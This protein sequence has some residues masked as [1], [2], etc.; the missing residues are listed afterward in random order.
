MG[1]I[2][3]GVPNSS[4]IVLT[5][6]DYDYSFTTEQERYDIRTK[7]G[8]L[9]SYLMPESTY[10]RFILPMSFVSSSNQ[11]LVGSWHSTA[12]D[13]RYIEDSSFANSYYT[14]RIVGTTQP[15][16]KF[17]QPYFR[18]EYEGQ[19]VIETI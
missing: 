18:Q 19:L 6:V 3:L 7:G 4:Y 1:D 10:K 8:S 2:L 9:F 15:F 5:D 11:S 13:L 14:V 12:T 16:T 17:V